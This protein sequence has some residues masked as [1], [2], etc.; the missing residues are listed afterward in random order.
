MIRRAKPGELGDRIRAALRHR[1][2]KGRDKLNQTSL[3]EASGITRASLSDLITGK[4]KD[5]K[6]STALLMA[7]VLGV[8]PE[9]LTFGSGEMVDPIRDLQLT[10]RQRAV[11]E[12]TTKMTP[13]QQQQLLQHCTKIVEENEQVRQAMEPKYP[14]PGAIRPPKK[15]RAAAS[16]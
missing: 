13:N 2:N 10:A 7:A 8:R 1:N 11:L 4:S 16:K 3:A 15:G 12:A 14:V 9:W 5:M 6:A